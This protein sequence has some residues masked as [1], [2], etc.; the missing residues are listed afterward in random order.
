M[1]KGYMTAAELAKKWNISVRRVQIL[2][3]SGE[4]EG[5]VKF[6]RSW[7]IPE[8][9]ERPKDGRLTSGEYKNWRNK[10]KKGDKQ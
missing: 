3:S 4:I 2:C 8:D 9:V 7:A 5:A 10:S 1:I 6:G